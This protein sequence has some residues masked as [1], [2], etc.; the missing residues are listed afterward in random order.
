MAYLVMPGTRNLSDLVTDFNAA[1]EPQLG[2]GWD[3]LEILKF[4]FLVQG[5]EKGWGLE[6]FFLL[7]R[8]VLVLFWGRRGVWGLADGRFRPFW[9][10]LRRSKR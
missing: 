2:S 5:K 4:F 7:M 9:V 1:E 8:C 3:F 6:Y 10:P